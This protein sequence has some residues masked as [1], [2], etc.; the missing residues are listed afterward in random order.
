MTTVFPTHRPMSIKTDWRSDLSVN[1]LIKLLFISLE[2]PDMELFKSMSVV[3][4]RK[5]QKEFGVKTHTHSLSQTH[6]LT[7]THTQTDINLF[8]SHC[9]VNNEM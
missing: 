9:S 1:T 4:G 3:V 7:Q 6:I 5:R 8:C 2:G